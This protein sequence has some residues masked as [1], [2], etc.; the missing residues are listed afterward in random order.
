MT[1]LLE[2]TKAMIELE[3]SLTKTLEK[4]DPWLATSTKGRTGIGVRVRPIP[5]SM[6]EVQ[7]VL[8]VAR[9]FSSRTSA[10]AGWNPNAPVNGF[11][12]PNP[13]PHQLRRGAL[14]ALELQRARQAERDKKR[15]RQEE[16]EEQNKEKEKQKTEEESN[17]NK[18]EI[19]AGGDVDGE[20][21]RAATE[22]KNNKQQGARPPPMR[23]RSTNLDRRAA[24]PVIATTMNLSDS[25]SDEDSDDDDDSD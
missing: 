18:M 7:E 6:D 13:L 24:R 21:K 15:K 23:G 22:N 10:P 1:T 19:D 16:L 3:R 12:T 5:T 20:K 8:A 2:K 14:A 4:V 9:N 25:S 11:S 17:K